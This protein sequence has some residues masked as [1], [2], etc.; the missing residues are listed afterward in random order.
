[1]RSARTT[2]IAFRPMV[3][4]QNRR[5]HPDWA[6]RL[7]DSRTQL[8][9]SV[10]RRSGVSG[11][12]SVNLPHVGDGRCTSKWARWLPT[13]RTKAI[14]SN[15]GVLGGRNENSV[16]PAAARRTLENATRDGGYPVLTSHRRTP[17]TGANVAGLLRSGRRQEL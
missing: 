6:P 14:R 17:S 7:D 15:L 16:K 4:P 13:Q 8:Q 3:S 11:D 2:P 10:N 1:M 5:P 9:C 12:L